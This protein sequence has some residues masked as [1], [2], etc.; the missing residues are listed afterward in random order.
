ML[1]VELSSLLLHSD[2]WYGNETVHVF[3]GEGF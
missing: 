2:S 3:A 1:G